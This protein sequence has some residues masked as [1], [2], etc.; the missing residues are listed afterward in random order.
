MFGEPDGVRSLDCV[1]SMSYMCFECG[2][3]CCYKFL[4]LLCGVCIALYWGCEFAVLSFDHVWC[5]TPAM[6]DFAI[7]IG[8]WQ[9]LFGTCLS[10]C[11]APVCEACG[12]IFSNIKITK[13]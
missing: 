9:K 7:C 10:C 4:T 12:G 6:R 11:L 8:C 3:N 2:K 1:W 5:L 13:L